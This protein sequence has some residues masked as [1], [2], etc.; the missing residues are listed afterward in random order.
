[1]IIWP[2]GSISEIIAK[3]KTKQKQK[4]NQK[5]KKWKERR[6]KMQQVPNL[7][8]FAGARARFYPQMIYILGPWIFSL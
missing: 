4:I 1:L 8:L 2:C 3:K 7:L 6:K 5:K